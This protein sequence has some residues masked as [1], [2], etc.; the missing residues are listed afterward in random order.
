MTSRPNDRSI[1]LDIHR[2]SVAQGI[3]FLVSVVVRA[4]NVVGCPVSRGELWELKELATDYGLEILMTSHDLPIMT[5]P[6]I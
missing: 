1:G 5:S 3:E 6:H 4:D 2:R